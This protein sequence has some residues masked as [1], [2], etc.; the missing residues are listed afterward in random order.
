[1]LPDENKIYSVAARWNVLL[2]PVGVEQVSSTG[3]FWCFFV[4]FLSGE[5]PAEKAEW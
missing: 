5:S 4:K 1:M 2:G 3:S